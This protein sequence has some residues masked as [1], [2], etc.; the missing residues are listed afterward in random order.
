LNV[1]KRLVRDAE[2]FAAEVAEFDEEE[3]I[4]RVHKTLGIAAEDDSASNNVPA[5]GHTRATGRAGGL[6]SQHEGSDRTPHDR[7]NEYL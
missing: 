3:L 1:G 6:T 5:A 4:A 7:P 2:S